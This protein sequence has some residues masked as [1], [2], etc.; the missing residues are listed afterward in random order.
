VYSGFASGTFGRRL[1][2]TADALAAT[3]V[4]TNESPAP[5]TLDLPHNSV[6]IDPAD[7]RTVWVGTDRGV[8][9]GR[10]DASTS[11]MTWQ[12]YGSETGLPNVIV[13]DVKVHAATRVPVAFTHG[14]G[15][16][17]LVDLAALCAG[18]WAPTQGSNFGVCPP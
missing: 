3:P 5:G 15:A 18:G 6:V 13:F 4:W 2:R 12:H 9:R 10:W 1:F 17:V 14:R 16:F 7:P 11:N 8:F